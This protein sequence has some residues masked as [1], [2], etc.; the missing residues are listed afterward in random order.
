MASSILAIEKGTLNPFMETYTVGLMVK[1]WQKNEYS[2]CER[3]LIFSIPRMSFNLASVTEREGAQVSTGIGRKKGAICSSKCHGGCKCN[4]CSDDSDA[5]Q[6]QRKKARRG[7]SSSK[8]LRQ[9]AKVPASPRQR[10]DKA[11]REKMKK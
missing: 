4:N 9:I 6:P 7:H 3:Q 10:N 1:G 5:N 8:H 2:L 11:T